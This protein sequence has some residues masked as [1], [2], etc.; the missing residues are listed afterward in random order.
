MELNPVF[1]YTEDGARAFNLG[2]AAEQTRAGE[3]FGVRELIPVDYWTHL[4][5]MVRR[6]SDDGVAAPSHRSSCAPGT[7]C[8]GRAGRRPS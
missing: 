2:P 5:Q 7:R 4:S 3:P 6:G 8:R 1:H